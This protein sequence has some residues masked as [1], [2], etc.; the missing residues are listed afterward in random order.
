MTDGDAAGEKFTGIQ[1]AQTDQ[2]GP[3]FIFKQG[4]YAALTR[5]TA[6]CRDGR[7]KGHG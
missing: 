4:G 1:D 6:I 5:N 7:I 2:T 3:V